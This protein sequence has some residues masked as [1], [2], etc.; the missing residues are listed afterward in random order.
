MKLEFT[1]NNLFELMS[2]RLDKSLKYS[3]TFLR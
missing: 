3:N 2:N 1:E